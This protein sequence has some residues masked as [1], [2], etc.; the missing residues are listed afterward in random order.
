MPRGAPPGGRST[1]PVWMPARI[2]NPSERTAL[3]TP[4]PQRTARAGPS[5]RAKKPS[6]RGVDLLAGVQLDLPPHELVMAAQQLCPSTVAES[7]RLTGRIDDVREQRRRE[8]AVLEAGRA[9]AGKK[10]LDLVDDVVPVPPGDVCLAGQLDEAGTGDVLCYVTAF[11]KLR[12]VV[13]AA[14]EYQRLRL[15]ARQDIADVDLR[16]HQYEGAGRRR[17]GRRPGSRHPPARE[18]FVRAWRHSRQI[19][20]DSPF[21]LDGLGIA[22]P[23]LPRLTPGVIVVWI[24]PLRVRAVED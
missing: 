16:V 18:P 12:V 7:L 2:S 11:F 19:G 3:R 22:L 20:L 4:T 5:K 6:P 1:S 24:H 13:V 8:D 15:D 9:D 21:A 17:A 10:F 23:L 14:V